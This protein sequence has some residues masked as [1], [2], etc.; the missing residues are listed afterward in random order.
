MRHKAWPLTPA[1]G[2]IAGHIIG[3]WAALAY[4]GFFYLVEAGKEAEAEERAEANATAAS[5]KKSGAK[6]AG[7]AGK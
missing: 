3:S 6:K 7:K 5:K 2:A 4:T 1:Y